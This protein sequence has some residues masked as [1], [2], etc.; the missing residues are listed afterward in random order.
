MLFCRELNEEQHFFLT[1]FQIQNRISIKNL[2]TFRS[3]IHLKFEFDELEKC[4]KYW[5]LAR[6]LL[7][8]PNFQINLY[9]REL[10]FT[11]EDSL[12]DLKI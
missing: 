2:G 9:P 11:N 8:T 7:N 3:Q 6:E 4:R 10:M 12:I 5:N 1:L